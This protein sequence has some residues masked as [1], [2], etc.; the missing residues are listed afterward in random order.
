MNE[1]TSATQQGFP[2]YSEKLFTR[3][4]EDWRY[5]W[6]TEA[7]DLRLPAGI[8]PRFFFIEGVEG[9][10]DYQETRKDGTHHYAVAEMSRFGFYHQAIIFND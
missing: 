4:A 8:F 10:F 6:T 2:R 7:S 1:T 5:R 3:T 9:R